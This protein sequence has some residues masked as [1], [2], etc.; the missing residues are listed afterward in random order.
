MRNPSMKKIIAHIYT[1][2]ICI[3]LCSCQKKNQIVGSGMIEINE[4]KIS[5]KL[6]GQITEIRVNEGDRVQKGDTMIIIDHKA[7]LAQE[8]EAMATLAV[9][10]KAYEE[11]HT[12]RINLSNRVARMDE[13]YQTGGVADQ[14]MEDL[15]TQVKVLQIQ[16]DK[17]LASL[18]AARARLNLVRTSLA[19][20]VIISPLSGIILSDNYEKGETVFPGAELLKIGNIKT[21]WLKIYMAEQ[22]IGKLRI[23]DQARVTVDAYPDEIFK[24]RVVWIASKAEFTP[25]N[26]QTK[27]DRTQLVFG[28]KIELNNDDEKLFPGMPA[29]AIIMNDEHR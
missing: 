23:G 4:V 21:A 13:V 24:G 6:T 28:V 14:D 8:K 3:L 17:T 19:D 15:R 12:Q 9:V 5:S 25:K 27:N 16:E 22:D 2:F 20:A 7:I 26:I 29:D 1:L 10:E 18:N 11:I